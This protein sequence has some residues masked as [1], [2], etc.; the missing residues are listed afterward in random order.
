MERDELTIRLGQRLRRLRQQRNMSLDA[1]SELTGVSK[2]MLGQIERGV[3]NPTVAT[4]WKIAS[5][6]NIPFTTFVADDTVVQVIRAH[7]QTVFYE[8][9][10]RFQVHSTYAGK[11]VPIELFRVELL[12]GCNRRAEAHA[13]GVI[14]SV[15]VIEG[16]LSVI[17]DGEEYSLDPGDT[18]N[19]SADILHSYENR[20]DVTCWATVAIIY[21]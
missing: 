9:N 20:T 19:F 21:R 17:V 8:D 7:E 13:S 5:G 15:T 1:L 12:P 16:V 2:P 18:L 10:Q 3:S 6:L 4:L 11:G 14:E